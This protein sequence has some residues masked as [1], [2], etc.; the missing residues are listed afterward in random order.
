MSIH[1][2]IPDHD[3]LYILHN[4]RGSYGSSSYGA[5]SYGGAAQEAPT[6]NSSAYGASS[7][8]SYGASRTEADQPAGRSQK[9][10]SGARTTA[11]GGS[12]GQDTE[13]AATTTPLSPASSRR[14][15]RYTSPEPSSSALSERRF[16]REDSSDSGAGYSSRFKRRD[17]SDSFVSRYLAKSRTSSQLAAESQK[18]PTPED[19][20]SATRKISGELQYPSG[21]SR[22]AALKERKAK[23]AKSKSSAMIGLGGNEEDDDDDSG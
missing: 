18:S 20:V 4:H 8:S 13:P 19:N 22:Y 16:S 17:D 12:W 9:S 10:Y 15:S 3:I 2:H 23:L 21:R 7:S 14:Y 1:G 6:R 5:S 11:Y